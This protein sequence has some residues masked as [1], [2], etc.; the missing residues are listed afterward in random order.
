[1]PR[2]TPSKPAPEAPQAAPAATHAG[3]AVEKALL[4]GAVR[5]L[6]S[7]QQDHLTREERAALRRH[8]KEQEERLRWQYYRTI[9]QK[10][11]REMTGRQTKVINEQADRYGLP[12]GGP[13]IDLPALARK[14]HDFLADNA[15]KLSK[16]D[17]PLLAGGGNS[18]ALEQYRQEKFLLARLDRQER[19]GDLIARDKA[20]EA[21]GRIAAILRG[22]GEALQRQYGSQA[23]EILHEALDDAQ[24]QI[25]QAFPKEINEPLSPPV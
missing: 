11:W 15:L 3:S 17:D 18:P 16:E 13:T 19:E 9:P 8:E 12:F 14:L 7:G 20:R 2:T 24:H 25:D 10:H 22:A 4:A 21:M 23:A 6:A 5:K 1:M